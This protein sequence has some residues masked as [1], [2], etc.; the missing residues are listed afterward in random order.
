MN[1]LSKTDKKTLLEHVQRCFRLE[2]VFYTQHARVEM[3]LEEFG[4]IQE[5]EAFEAV[6]SGKVIE[7]YEEGEPYPSILIYGR[8]AA[9]RPI[10]VVC[11]YVPVITVYEPNPAWWIN[12]ERRR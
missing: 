10:H 5:R 8:T 4:P 9:G 7:R 3:R 6:Q 11:A 12:F 2:Q 1:L